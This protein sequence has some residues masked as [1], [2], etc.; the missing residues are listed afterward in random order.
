MT[1]TGDILDKVWAMASPL[2][3]LTAVAE[4]IKDLDTQ[5]AVSKIGLACGLSL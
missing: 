5:I 1:L 2:T 4:V 3:G